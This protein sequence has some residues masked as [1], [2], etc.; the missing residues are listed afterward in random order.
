MKQD[1]I[2]THLIILRFIV[3]FL[4]EKE[5][6]GW[7]DTNFLSKT[8]LKF[9]AINFPRS[10]LTAGCTSVTAAAKRLHDERI[11]K[12]GVFHLF[13]LPAS[14]EETVHRELMKVDQEEIL[15][16]LESKDAA[17]VVLKELFNDDVDAPSGPVQIGTTKNI[18]SDSAIRGLAG[19]YYDAFSTGKKTFPYFMEK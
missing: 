5:Q 15:P 1:K 13:R 3:G 2:L 7:W 17:M 6:F 18:L 10:A 19:R 8:G 16:H 14:I 9:L 12:G 4:G 11:G